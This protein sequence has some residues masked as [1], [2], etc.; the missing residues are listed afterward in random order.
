MQCK[1]ESKTVPNVLINSKPVNCRG[2]YTIK[3]ESKQWIVAWYLWKRRLT[4]NFVPNY[5]NRIIN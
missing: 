1:V 2:K 4:T 3:N 5:V